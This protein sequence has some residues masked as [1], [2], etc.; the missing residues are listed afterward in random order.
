[1]GGKVRQVPYHLELIIQ[2]YESQGH[3][4]DVDRVYGS[5][6]NRCNQF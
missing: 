3:A 2:L 6:D 1:M 5:T 4:R